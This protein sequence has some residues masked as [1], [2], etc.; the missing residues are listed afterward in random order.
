M[1]TGLGF[2]SA[3]QALTAALD[4]PLRVVFKDTGGQ[5]TFELKLEPP[6]L[7]DLVQ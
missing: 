3:I 6:A 2:S 7:H 5:D 1:T 4:W